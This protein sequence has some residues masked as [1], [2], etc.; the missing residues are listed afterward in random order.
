MSRAG[1]DAS[2]GMGDR[3]RSAG[4]AF[5]GAALSERATRVS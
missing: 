5:I 2:S 1:H 3:E 4:M